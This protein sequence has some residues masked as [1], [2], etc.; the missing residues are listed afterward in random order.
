MPLKSFQFAMTSLEKD[1]YSKHLLRRDN[2]IRNE[3]AARVK[4]ENDDASHGCVIHYALTG[5][6]ESHVACCPLIF[7]MLSVLII[8]ACIR[9]NEIHSE[10]K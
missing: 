8:F 7:S 5:C 2:K 1:F 9:D 4:E 6:H 3:K 10:G